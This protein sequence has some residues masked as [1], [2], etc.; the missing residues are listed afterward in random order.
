MVK[1]RRN[2]H[3]SITLR[4]EENPKDPTQEE[5]VCGGIVVKAL[6]YKPA[7]HRFDSQWCH[8]NFSET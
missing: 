2:P 5:G 4:W 7:G 3:H 6:C 8:L 1:K